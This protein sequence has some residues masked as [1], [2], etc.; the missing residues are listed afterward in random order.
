MSCSSFD[1]PFFCPFSLSSFPI[2][3][4]QLSC[5]HNNKYKKKNFANHSHPCSTTHRYN[6]FTGLFGIKKLLNPEQ[7]H[8]TIY[9][10]LLL[11]HK[12]FLLMLPSNSDSQS[13]EYYYYYYYVTIVHRIRGCDRARAASHPN[14]MDWMSCQVIADSHSLLLFEPQKNHH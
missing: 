14:G 12:R 3:H 13:L 9:L 4:A 11:P 5:N 2:N 7:Q 1:L 10:I 8:F 6:I